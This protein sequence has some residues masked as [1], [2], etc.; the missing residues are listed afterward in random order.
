MTV[1][2][3]NADVAR[4]TIASDLSCRAELTLRTL[5]ALGSVRKAFQTRCPVVAILTEYAIWH[6]RIPVTPAVCGTLCHKAASR[7]DKSRFAWLTLGLA[8]GWLPPTIS[9]GSWRT[10]S[11]LAEVIHW[12]LVAHF[13]DGST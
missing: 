5:V 7:A 6:C 9:A 1:C 12:A 4:G 11:S 3:L 13:Q 8:N 10:C 2:L